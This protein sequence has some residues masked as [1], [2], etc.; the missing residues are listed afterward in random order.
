MLV[1]VLELVLKMFGLSDV[2]GFTSSLLEKQSEMKIPFR[3]ET[4]KQFIPSHISSD[5]PQQRHSQEDQSTIAW[6][7][8]EKKEGKPFNQY[9]IDQFVGFCYMLI[10][11]SLS[12]EVYETTFTL[13]L[14]TML[15]RIPR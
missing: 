5:R 10:K 1:F 12:I 15:L 13:H 7:G 2:S 11:K 4:H 3:W 8:C 6:Y 14:H 9:F